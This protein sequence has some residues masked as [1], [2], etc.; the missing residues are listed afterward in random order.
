M[1]SESRVELILPDYTKSIIDPQGSGVG[2]EDL[3]AAECF[4]LV[5][6]EPYYG[7]NYYVTFESKTSLNTIYQVIT[8]MELAKLSDDSLSFNYY[9]SIR[10]D[11][12]IIMAVEMNIKALQMVNIILH[13]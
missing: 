3:H 2:S 13:S 8:K 5:L 4:K 9:H 7:S 11:K 10:K 6:N 12:H 1:C